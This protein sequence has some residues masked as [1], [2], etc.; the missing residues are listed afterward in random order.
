MKDYKKH[1]IDQNASVND[2]FQKLNI[3]ASNAIL[4]LIDDNSKL[5]GS[6]TDGDLRRGFIQNKNFKTKLIDFIQKNPKKIL[7]NKFL[8]SEIVKSRN[9]GFKVIPIVNNDDIIIDILNLRNYKSYLPVHAFIMAGGKGKRLRPLTLSTPKPL[10][11]IGSKPIIEHNI[12]RLIKYGIKNIDISVKYLGDQIKNYFKNGSSKSIS[13][14]YINEIKPLGTIGS[15][16]NC[17][18]FIMTTYW[19]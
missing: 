9:E 18:I 13:I 12:D 2:A 1:L 15:L 6:L 5:L 11:E 3:L 4:F 14:S 10:L 7:K 8:V 19:S 16:K 17:K